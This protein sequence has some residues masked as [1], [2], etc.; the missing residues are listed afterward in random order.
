MPHGVPRAIKLQKG[1][2]TMDYGAKVN[3]YCSDM[4]R[5]VCI[6]KADAEMKQVYN[7][8]LEAQNAALE[9]YARANYVDIDKRARYIA[10]AVTGECSVTSD[11]A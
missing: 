5:T 3:G 2:L 1:F 11:T 8:V 4:T 9:K 10:S 6:G 7:T